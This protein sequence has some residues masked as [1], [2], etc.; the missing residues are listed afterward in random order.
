MVTPQQ[1]GQVVVKSIGDI[2]RESTVRARPMGSRFAQVAGAAQ[3]IGGIADTARTMVSNIGKVSST[4]NKIATNPINYALVGAVLA[5]DTS[6]TWVLQRRGNKDSRFRST[7]NGR[8]LLLTHL[9]YSIIAPVAK[10]ILGKV[11]S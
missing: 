3:T 10:V 7:I 5:N 1:R 6:R 4:Y 11:K 2:N 9:G 8:Y